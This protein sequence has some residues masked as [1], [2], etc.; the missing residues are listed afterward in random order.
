[1]LTVTLGELPTSLH[2]HRPKSE[3]ALPAVIVLPPLPTIPLC[4]ETRANYPWAKMVRDALIPNGY[5]VRVFSRTDYLGLWRVVRRHNQTILANKGSKRVKPLPL[6][7]FN[8]CRV[9][10]VEKPITPEGRESILESWLGRVVPMPESHAEAC[11]EFNILAK[12][13]LT[14]GTPSAQFIHKANTHFALENDFIVMPTHDEAER[15]RVLMRRYAWAKKIS[16]IEDR[17]HSTY[18]EMVTE[19]QWKVGFTGTA[20]KQWLKENWREALGGEHETV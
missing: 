6:Y 4:G 15:M 9:E 11:K 8:V 18:I 16:A 14:Y 7:D 19:T 1:M 20:H 10:S 12:S 5:T 13:A 3:H 2:A 17:T